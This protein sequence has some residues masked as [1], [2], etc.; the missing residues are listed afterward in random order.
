[1]GKKSFSCFHIKACFSFLLFSRVCN[2]SRQALE[3]LRAEE[4]LREARRW[5][6]TFLSGL[7]PCLSASLCC[8]AAVSLQLGPVAT[9]VAR[10]ERPPWQTCVALCTA[11]KH[12]LMRSAAGWAQA[13]GSKDILEERHCLTKNPV[14]R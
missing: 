11:N 14:S 4:P 7:P 2:N 8:L 5:P 12:S 6:S 13:Y 1:M 10:S 3:S 9:S